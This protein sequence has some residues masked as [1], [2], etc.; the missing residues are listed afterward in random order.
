MTVISTVLDG[1]LQR[2]ADSWRWRDGAPEPRVR[3]MLVADNAPNFR[4]SRGMVEIPRDWRSSRYWP[5][6]QG[7]HRVDPQAAEEITRLI[8]DIGQPGAVY[9]DAPDQAT[10]QGYLIPVAQW[11]A[12]MR[13]PCGVW[14]DA[15]DEAAILDRAYALGWSPPPGYA[16]PQGWQPQAMMPR[17]H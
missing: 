4:V 6:G 17:P 11:D 16:S 5:T 13:E 14:W 10:H 12:A 8:Q 7:R 3:D 2:H 9:A 15:Q 1:T